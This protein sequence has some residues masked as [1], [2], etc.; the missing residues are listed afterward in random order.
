MLRADEVRS[1]TRGQLGYNGFE[2]IIPKFRGPAPKLEI[3]DLLVL[4]N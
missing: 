4:I 3:Q 1:L 2:E